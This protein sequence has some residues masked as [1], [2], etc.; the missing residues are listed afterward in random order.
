MGGDIFRIQI[1]EPAEASLAV[2]LG[3]RVAIPVDRHYARDAEI[4]GDLLVVRSEGRGDVHD[5][6]T[7]LGGHIVSGDDAESITLDR[8]EPAD[9][10]T[11]SDTDEVGT[12]E[13][14]FQ[15]PVWDHLVA[16]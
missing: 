15:N 1:L 12:L 8:R 10:L 13:L 14:P 3:L 11:V 4:G 6:G 7:V 16:L 5:A 9:Q 2:H